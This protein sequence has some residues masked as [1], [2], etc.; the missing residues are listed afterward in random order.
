MVVFAHGRSDIPPHVHGHE[1]NHPKLATDVDRSKF[2]EDSHANHMAGLYGISDRAMEHNAADPQDV[3]WLV[4]VLNSA[5]MNTDRSGD[6][7]F[8]ATMIWINW[9]AE[10]RHPQGN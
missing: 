7:W 6:Q 4:N 8:H 2:S 10:T 3:A 1:T 5:N 9:L